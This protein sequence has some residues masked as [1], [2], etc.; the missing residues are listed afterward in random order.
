MNFPSQTDSFLHGDLFPL[1]EEQGLR[2]DFAGDTFEQLRS[3]M[4]RYIRSLPVEATVDLE[5]MVD[6]ISRRYPFHAESDGAF[7]EALDS[8]VD[9]GWLQVHGNQIELNKVASV[10]RRYFTRLFRR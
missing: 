10:T 4:L 9:E 6:D 7:E 8:L 5:T 2:N 3:I 1:E